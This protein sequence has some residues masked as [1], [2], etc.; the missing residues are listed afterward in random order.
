MDTPLKHPPLLRRHREMGAAIAE[1][2][3]WQVARHF[4]SPEEEARRVRDTAGLAD[5]S[6]ISKFDLKGYGLS[7]PPPAEPGVHH[8]LLAPGHYLVTSQDT[9]R[10]KAGLN[11][12]APARW[13]EVTS[14]YAALLL[15]GPRSRDVL[16]KL[17]S[18][19][20]SDS[21]LPDGAC[22][23]SG[24]SHVHAIV[25][26]Q[27]VGGLLTFLVLVGREYAEFVWDSIMHA[28]HEYDIT[29]FGIACR[30]LLGGL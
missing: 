11:L 8:W 13:T 23:Q 15:A 19:N 28:G 3:G 2:D 17:T 25:L 9:G 7:S 22:A 21:A 12:P 5:W 4:T 30:S 1:H 10:A 24:L 16:A 27:D 26:R 20:V 14:L 6:W 18:L 29:P